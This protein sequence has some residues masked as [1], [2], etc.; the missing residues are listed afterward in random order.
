[1]ISANNTETNEKVA[2]KKLAHI[3]DVVSE[4]FGLPGKK[5]SKNQS[6]NELNVYRSMR[7]E[8]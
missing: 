4:V 2:I 6:H 8:F 5:W 1:M 7:R 3:E